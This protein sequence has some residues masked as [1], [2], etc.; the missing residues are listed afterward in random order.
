MNE[1]NEV[2][3]VDGTETGKASTLSGLTVST[4]KDYGSGSVLAPSHAW[5]AGSELI[6]LIGYLNLKHLAAYSSCSV[7][8]LRN[9]LTDRIR[10]LPYYRIEGKILVR[11][12]EFDRWMSGFRVTSSENELDMIVESVVAQIQHGKRTT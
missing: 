10:P 4:S 11:R 3:V 8:W 1:R 5:N 9:R 6:G 12:D 2:G 7:R